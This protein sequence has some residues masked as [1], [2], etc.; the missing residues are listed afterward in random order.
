MRSIDIAPT[1][2]RLAGAASD[3]QP[4]SGESLA[5]LLDGGSRPEIPVS[6]AESWY[7][8]LHFGWSELRSARVGEWKYI[9]APKPELYDLRV[10]RGESKQPGEQPCPGR[11]QAGCG[12]ARSHDQL[13]GGASRLAAGT[14]GRRDSRTTPGPRL[15]REL[16]ARDGF[17]VERESEGSHRRVPAV[18]R[19][20]R[21]RA[22]PAREW[23]AGRR[24]SG[25]AADPEV[26]RA[27]LRSAPAS[28]ARLLRA[29]TD[30]CRA[31]GI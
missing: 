26:Q 15:C 18:S 21:S 31:G 29:G 25:P 23:E 7:P 19:V 16:C 6:I 28:R 20:V 17:L 9:A 10:D 8:R 4:A 13:S 14:A 2:A 3:A 1:I 12:R 27:G 24:G 22:R 11:G 30:G 5:V